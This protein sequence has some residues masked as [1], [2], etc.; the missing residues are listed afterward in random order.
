M[1]S[2]PNFGTSL[3]RSG[4][5]N[6][7]P[8]YGNTRLCMSN[9]W[10]RPW[11]QHRASGPVWEGL[12][13]A[14]VFLTFGITNFACRI[15]AT[16]HGLPNRGP[17]LGRHGRSNCHPYLGN[18]KRCMSNLCHRQ[19]IRHRTL[20]PVWE[21]LDRAI[22]ILTPGILDCACR[23]FATDYGFNTEPRT[24]SGKAGKGQLSSLPR[25]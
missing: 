16:D 13:R 4:K 14:I 20:A 21:G 22:V 17:R 10:H 1:D 18:N 2:T 12:E 3:G 15:F 5:G 6:C 25:E 11:I 24:Q 8:Y 19:W 7:H 9:L 23:I